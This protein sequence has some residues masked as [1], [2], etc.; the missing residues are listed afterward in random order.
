MGKLATMNC[1]IWENMMPPT[2]NRP[3]KTIFFENLALYSKILVS[4]YSFCNCPNHFKLNCR[5]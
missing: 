1:K 3:V 5:L 4:L 2:I